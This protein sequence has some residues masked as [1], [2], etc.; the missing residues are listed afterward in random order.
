MAEDADFDAEFGDDPDFN[1]SGGGWDVSDGEDDPFAM[2]DPNDAGGWGSDPELETNAASEIENK[3]IE[4]YYEKDDMDMK[5]ASFLKVIELINA[6]GD[7]T[8]DFKFKSLT[9]IVVL[10][11]G[12]Q[13]GNKENVIRYFGEFLNESSKVKPNDLSSNLRKILNQQDQI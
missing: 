10:Y 9:E 2:D 13:N 1:E 5:L 11:I 8:D 3:Y 4:A 7:D 6:G 12:Q